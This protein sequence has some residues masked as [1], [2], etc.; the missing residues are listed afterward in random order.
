[1]PSHLRYSSSY[2]SSIPMSVKI[3]NYHKENKLM[4]SMLCQINHTFKLFYR[5]FLLFIFDIMFLLQNR[6][7]QLVYLTKLLNIFYFKN[8]YIFHISYTPS[9]W[10]ILLIKVLKFRKSTWLFSDNKWTCLRNRFWKEVFSCKNKLKT[11]I[12]NYKI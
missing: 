4:L 5:K 11:L 2:I 3:Q 9:L 7:C 10:T 8:K 12:I 1:M 6:N